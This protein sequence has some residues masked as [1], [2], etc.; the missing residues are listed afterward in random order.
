MKGIIDVEE[1]RG[2][3]IWSAL[4]PCSGQNEFYLG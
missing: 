3:Q 4:A 1:E 2:S